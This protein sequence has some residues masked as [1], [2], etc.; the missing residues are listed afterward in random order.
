MARLLNS[1][2]IVM[3]ALSLMAVKHLRQLRLNVLVGVDRCSA[4]ASALL[5]T[6]R[7]AA[8]YLELH[9]LERDAVVQAHLDESECESEL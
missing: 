6:M 9:T 1:F 8:K 7:V 5:E 3:G 2:G 4:E